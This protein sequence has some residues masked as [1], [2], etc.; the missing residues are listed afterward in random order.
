MLFLKLKLSTKCLKIIAKMNIAVIIPIYNESKIINT[1]LHNPAFNKYTVVV[2]DDASKEQLVLNSISSPLYLLTHSKNLGQGAALQT[3]MDFCKTIPAD[4]VIHFD[5]DGQHQVSDIENLIEP[6]VN[7]KADIT[8]GSRFLANNI[9]SEG[10]T[11]PFFKIVILKLAKVIQY[12][13]TGIVL[14]DSQNGLRALSKKTF[15]TLQLKENRMAHAIE[16]IQ[17][18]VKNK[19]I[20]KEVPVNILYSTYSMHKGQKFYNG[21]LICVRLLLN[22]AWWVAA[23]IGTAITAAVFFYNKALISKLHFY[24]TIAFVVTFG[25]AFL[26]FVYNK[27]LQ[28]KATKKIRQL[29]LAT[30]QSI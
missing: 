27:K 21:F 10:T 18:S 24:Y 23:I 9:Q 12:I 6:I 7:N 13:F 17:L 16:I 8:I 20:I 29:S 14:S 28:V 22:S 4:I 5:G 15:T 26:L 11:I 3:G 30:V 19:L 25:I 1:I 2:V